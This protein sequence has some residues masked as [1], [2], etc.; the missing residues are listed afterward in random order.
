MGQ[1]DYAI[2]GQMKVRFQTIRAD[3]YSALESP[4]G[5]FRELGFVAPVGDRLWLSTSRNIFTSKGK[6]G[7]SVGQ[8]TSTS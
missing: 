6:F 2:F 3:L 1:H 5:I 8:Y 7:Y 4:H